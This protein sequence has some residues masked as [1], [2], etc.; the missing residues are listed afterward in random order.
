MKIT[1][2]AGNFEELELLHQYGVSEVLLG[3]K[4]LSR[5]GK[6]DIHTL[7]AMAKKANELH[8]H[9]VLEW[10]ILMTNDRIHLATETLAKVELNLFS[11]IRVQDSGALAI[12]KKLS[13]ALP[14]QLILET[15]NHNLEGV[16]RWC[17]TAGNKLERVILSSELTA[18]TLAHYI[19]YISVPIEVLGLGPILLFYTPRHL[20]SFQNLPPDR[21]QNVI[22]N[23]E[24]GFHKGFRLLEND[25]G[26]FMFHAKDYCLMDRLDR[27]VEMNLHS[28][29]IDLRMNPDW[30]DL[31]TIATL[32]KDANDRKFSLDAADAFIQQYPQRV[33]RCFFQANA[34]DVLFKKLS[35]ENI[36]RNDEHF[37]GEVVEVAK[38]KYILIHVQSNKLSL[39]REGMYIFTTPEGKSKVVTITR[40]TDLDRNELQEARKNDFVIIPY[41]KSITPKTMVYENTH[42]ES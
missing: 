41:Q 25:H 15:G 19:E 23:S 31:A 35:N 11:A 9:P 33:T 28:L 38:E 16:K 34:T 40:L 13:P 10:D 29:R 12:V 17:D 14:I 32:V 8:L 24:E 42:L 20:L 30:S 39:K 6:L 18:Q 36:V 2:A 26:T 27:L 5:F 7:H 22:A 1:S 4:E 21:Y 37:I 3:L